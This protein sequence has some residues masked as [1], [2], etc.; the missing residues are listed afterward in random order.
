ML[1][2]WWAIFFGGGSRM[3]MSSTASALGG[4]FNRSLQLTFL[5]RSGASAGVGCLGERD[6]RDPIGHGCS[7]G[8]VVL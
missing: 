8:G 6:K 5:H 1:C 7:M 2:V 3:V 4:G